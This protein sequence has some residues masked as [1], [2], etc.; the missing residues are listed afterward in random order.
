LEFFVYF[1]KWKGPKSDLRV[2]RRSH[3]VSDVQNLDSPFALTIRNNMEPLL[4][5]IFLRID[6]YN[7][8]FKW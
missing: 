1:L 3:L 7:I 5:L 6:C 2:E 8:F 4:Y